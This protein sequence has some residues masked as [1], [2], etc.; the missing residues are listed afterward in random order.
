MAAAGGDIEH[1]VR[2]YENLK[3]DESLETSPHLFLQ[4]E[5][6]KKA[7]KMLAVG[8]SFTPEYFRFMDDNR[9][10]MG[11]R[12]IIDERIAGNQVG[13]YRFLANPPIPDLIP[14]VVDALP[15]VMKTQSLENIRGLLTLPAY[16]RSR[17]IDLGLALNDEDP[18]EEISIDDLP[19]SPLKALHL[20]NIATFVENNS[21][22]FYS[23]DKS[24]EFHIFAPMIATHGGGIY[25]LKFL[26][27]TSRDINFQIY[28]TIYSIT[29]EEG[30]RRIPV[31]TPEGDII[32][33]HLE[34][35]IVPN[36]GIPFPRYITY[37]SPT[38]GGYEKRRMEIPRKNPD[39]CVTV[40]MFLAGYLTQPDMTRY[41]NLFR[42]IV[43]KENS[44]SHIR[45]IN[46]MLSYGYDPFAST[47]MTSRIHS[48]Y[49]RKDPSNPLRKLYL[50]RLY[51][52][53]VNR[54]YTKQIGGIAF[55]GYHALPNLYTI[56][57]VDPAKTRAQ[58]YQVL[59]DMLD[60]LGCNR[61]NILFPIGV[62]G[63]QLLLSYEQGRYL[64]RDPQ[65]DEYYA[66]LMDHPNN[67]VYPARTLS[68]Y[69]Y[70]SLFCAETSLPAQHFAAV[71]PEMGGL[72]SYY[73]NT[74]LFKGDPF[75][76]VR[77]TVNKFIRHFS[78]TRTRPVY[79]PVV[80][81]KLLLQSFPFNLDIKDLRLSR[82][83]EEAAIIDEESLGL[84]RW[85]NHDISFDYYNRLNTG[86]E[87]VEKSLGNVA[88]LKSVR[89]FLRKYQLSN[90]ADIMRR[91]SRSVGLFGF[92]RRKY[93]GEDMHNLLL[94]RPLFTA[95]L[96]E[97][98]SVADDGVSPL[99]TRVIQQHS[100]EV[101]QHIAEYLARSEKPVLNLNKIFLDSVWNNPA[102]VKQ[103][104]LY[105]TA[106]LQRL[107]EL[108][109]KLEI[110]DDLE[111]DLVE[112]LEQYG[113]QYKKTLRITVRNKVAS[114][115]ATTRVLL[116]EGR[117][118]T[119]A[120]IAKYFLTHPV[121]REEEKEKYKPV[122]DEMV[123]RVILKRLR[124]ASPIAE[125]ESREQAEMSLQARRIQAIRA[126][127]PSRFLP[128]PEVKRLTRA[129]IQQGK[130][131]DYEQ[132][133]RDLEEEEKQRQI[134]AIGKKRTA[135]EVLKDRREEDLTEEYIDEM[136]QAERER[137]LESAWSDEDSARL[138]A[139]FEV[140]IRPSEREK[141][142]GYD[143]M[144]ALV[145][146]IRQSRPDKYLGKK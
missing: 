128:L 16:I 80:G 24:K 66:D 62:I 89:N 25:T 127:Q 142:D 42:H 74:P 86:I 59:T 26:R 70:I 133:L 97:Y 81:E 98:T 121:P 36:P 140:A 95:F 123:K 69:G 91:Y 7:N 68:P 21:W 132:A 28:P 76:L 101:N 111:K 113:R 53:P 33:F 92:F 46:H 71:C 15:Q 44:Q 135:K 114:E 105:K 116:P 139:E 126:A 5:E 146:I 120:D 27:L 122:S 79:Q 72:Y 55:G 137:L 50:V 61:E 110:G 11:H 32:E 29:V 129:Q 45:S 103:L 115:I 22:T 141:L 96:K 47:V 58:N 20:S 65:V 19:N 99:S 109:D 1:I 60:L 107:V 100:E 124:L 125:L 51:F 63:H 38:A 85:P 23:N 136:I 143:T 82:L 78:E 64:M 130:V 83:R 112:A 14:F 87:Q 134:R 13:S 88:G 41:H 67:L 3:E 30:G 17:V 40:S 56:N 57:V 138:R 77:N 43:I 31:T 108:A 10:Y 119:A 75:P 90:E 18:D 102:A 54:D 145:A 6:E 131:L 2:R 117:I 73:Q 48:F 9:F 35:G 37:Y 94:S 49:N 12:Y 144:I 118:L 106:S 34:V 93:T 104:A 84:I 52:G 4:E 8:T 39:D